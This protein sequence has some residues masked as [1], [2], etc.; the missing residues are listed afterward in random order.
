MGTHVH[1]D[2][3][4]KM[5]QNAEKSPISDHPGLHLRT[6]RDCRELVAEDHSDAHNEEEEPSGASPLPLFLLP[7]R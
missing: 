6:S 4:R 1:A 7:P 2:G 3:V 5:Q